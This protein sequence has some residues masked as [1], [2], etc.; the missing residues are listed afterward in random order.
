M[1]RIN[2]PTSYFLCKYNKSIDLL[3][4]NSFCRVKSGLIKTQKGVELIFL[5]ELDSH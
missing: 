3:N 2:Q 4:L 5:I 1:K